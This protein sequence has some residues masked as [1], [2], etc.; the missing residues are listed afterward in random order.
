V[1]RNGAKV[2]TSTSASYTDTGLTASTQYSYTVDAFDAAGDTSARSGALTVSTAAAPCN[3]DC[4]PP[5]APTGLLAASETASTIA[6]SWTAATDNVGVTGYKVL[7]DGAQVGTPTATSFTDTG[8]SAA[9]QH[10]YTVEAVD[11]AGN[12]SAASGALTV[13]T[14]AA[15][16]TGYEAESPANTLAGGALLAS[17]SAASGG[18]VV[19]YVGNGGTLT[20][21]NV[22]AATAGRYTLGIAYIDGDA[23]RSATVT[24]DGTASSLSFTGT[25]DSN[26]NR[27]QTLTTTVSLNASGTNTIVFSNPGGWA[28]DIDQITLAP[29]SGGGDTTPPSVPTGL[30]STAH[31]ASSVS[32]SWTASTDNVGVTGY[33][34]LRNGTQVGTTT[35][36]SFTDIGLTASTQYSYTVKAYDA[37]GNVSAASGALS[38]TT[39]AASSATTYEADAAANVLAGGAKVMACAACA[40][41]HDVGYVGNGGT[42]TFTGVSK[43]VAG[44]YTLTIAYV[45][46]DAGRSATVT[47]NGV[48]TTVTFPGTND[49]NWNNVQTTSVT[50]GLSAGTNTV[51]FSNPSGWAPDISTITV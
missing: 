22:S 8:L 27:V 46:G 18:E 10:S 28:P 48:A 4:V 26:W 35:A 31:T 41:G 36:T 15:G 2:G 21:P 6:F 20:F 37:A 29:A 50:V 3:G 14:T 43:T 24:V 38:V 47:V 25:N 12:V 45:D 5:S 23:G 17:A 9:G 34:V 32:L 1:Y 44:S 40:D 30:T 7:R 11:A 42:L 13:S 19:G 39:S 49:G 51:V 16:T 33:Q